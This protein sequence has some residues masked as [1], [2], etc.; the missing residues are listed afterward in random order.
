MT[1]HTRSDYSGSPEAEA[2]SQQLDIWQQTAPTFSTEPP[3]ARESL[4]HALDE[5][6]SNAL[7]YRTGPELREL[8]DFSCRFPHLAP[9]NA[10]LLHVQNPGIRYALPPAYW[11]REFKRRIKPGARPYVVLIPFGPVRFVFDLSDTEP[12]NPTEDR[13]P[14]KAINP[15]GAKGEPPV[16]ALSNMEKACAKLSIQVKYAE[17]ATHLAGS[18]QRHTSDSWDFFLQLNNKHASYPSGDRPHA[19]S[20]L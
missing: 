10:M 6:V 1:R 19:T 4:K 14:E 18:V 13:V 17:L 5:L 20:L 8:L 9:Y 15:F 16:S 11:K 2:Y 3:T 12:I 7:A